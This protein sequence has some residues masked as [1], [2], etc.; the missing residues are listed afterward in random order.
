MTEIKV[1]LDLLRHV[2]ALAAAAVEPKMHRWPS[3]GTGGKRKWYSLD[4]VVSAM[5]MVI[6]WWRGVKMIGTC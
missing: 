5:K 4:H 1:T 2:G 3:C 6:S